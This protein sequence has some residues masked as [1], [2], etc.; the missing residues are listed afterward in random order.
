MS[1]RNVV[2]ALVFFSLL[3]GLGSG[4]ALAQTV[5]SLN[6]PAAIPSTTADAETVAGIVPIR[7]G[8]GN[9]TIL[10]LYATPTTA[11]AFTSTAPARVK[12]QLFS[13]AGAAG[14]EVVTSL[15]STSQGALK[16]INA[17]DD[18]SA[19]ADGVAVIVRASA[20]GSD[21]TGVLAGSALYIDA[22]LGSV[23]YG[24]APIMT[25]G[26]ANR[27]PGFNQL[28]YST[29]ATTGI[30][31]TTFHIICPSSG[32]TTAAISSPSAFA[33]RLDALGNFPNGLSEHFDITVFDSS[34]NLKGTTGGTSCRAANFQ[35]KSAADL[36]GFFSSAA[37][38][39]FRMR[40]SS[41]ATHSSDDS[42]GDL[43]VWRILTISLGVLNPFVADERAQPLSGN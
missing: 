17:K 6:D 33:T 1:A 22:T 34:G 10:V 15:T 24:R 11:D 31:A 26:A 29:F 2:S 38:G 4:Q 36:S 42:G 7:A 28:H 19:T 25:R 43:I 14:T 40:G 32:S 12:I 41:A 23:F 39:F 27:I 3:L 20:S 21:S 5:S 8:G 16:K 13:T 35:N 37:D 18:L 30:F 9:N